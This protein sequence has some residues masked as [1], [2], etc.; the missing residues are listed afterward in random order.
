MPAAYSKI[1]IARPAGTPAVYRND[2][3]GDPHL[4]SQ[5]GDSTVRI[6]FDGDDQLAKL[7]DRIDE[8]LDS[9]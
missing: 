2:E 5:Q 8:V 6:T 3:D 9:E 1:H 4:R 7:R